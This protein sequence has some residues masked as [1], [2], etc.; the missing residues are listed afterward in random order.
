MIYGVYENI[1]CCFEESGKFICNVDEIPDGAVVYYKFSDITLIG[2]FIAL[3]YLFWE[4]E[5]THY[6]VE[7]LSIMK[8]IYCEHSFT[9]QFRKFLEQWG[10]CCIADDILER[11]QAYHN[12]FYDAQVVLNRSSITIG[13]TTYKNKYLFGTVSGRF[14]NVSNRRNLLAISKD[15]KKSV[16]PEYGHFVQIDMKAFHFNIIRL[17]YGIDIP[18]S[19]YDW[20]VDRLGC[21]RKE[22]KLMC[23]KWMNSDY[24]G[25]APEFI[26][27]IRR[28]Q[29]EKGL[30]AKEF[31]Y[32]LQ[33]KENELMCRFIVNIDK[34]L[35]LL[36]LEYSICNYCY[37]SLTIDCSKRTVDVIK[38]ILGNDVHRI[39]IM[40]K[41]PFTLEIY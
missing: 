8:G 1:I 18:V 31:N 14:T 11:A 34:V 38:K 33:T 2:N 24:K 7:E 30:S 40:G 37:D 17:F 26:K 23:L 28:L 39:K 4:I 27:K 16:V 9:R 22:A 25:S 36:N 41:Y 19:P 5:K 12:M 3:E 13:S 35:H 32:E 20:L 10:R 6:R 29:V 15:D 21:T